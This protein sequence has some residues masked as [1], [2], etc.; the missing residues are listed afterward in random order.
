MTGAPRFA[1]QQLG[2][3]AGVAQ[4][5]EALLSVMRKGGTG[6]RASGLAPPAATGKITYTTM[7]EVN[8]AAV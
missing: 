4:L 2:S 1:E 6:L 3:S 7:G 5:L 8:M